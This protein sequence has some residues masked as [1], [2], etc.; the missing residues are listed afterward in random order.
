MDYAVTD[1][2]RKTLRLYFHATVL[3]NEFFYVRLHLLNNRKRGLNGAFSKTLMNMKRLLF[4]VV[5]TGIVCSICAQTGEN[6]FE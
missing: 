5:F 2:G 6:I 4:L 3:L 1:E